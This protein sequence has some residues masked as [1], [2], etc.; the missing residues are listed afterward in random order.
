MQGV[1]ADELTLTPGGFGGDRQWALIDVDSGRLMSAKR[2]S[3]LLQ[4][5]ADD[6]GI[7]LPDGARVAFGDA[8][9]DAVL[10]AWLGRRVHLAQA[11]DSTTVSY[12][13]TFDPPDDDAEYYAIEAPAGSHLDLCAAHLV[14]EPTLRSA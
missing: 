2:W 5:S 14:A 12:E 10:S 13:M 3:A 11:E 4:A 8:E 6:D 7:T 1:E 9:A